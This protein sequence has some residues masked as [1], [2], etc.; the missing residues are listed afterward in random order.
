MNGSVAGVPGGGAPAHGGVQDGGGDG[1]DGGAFPGVG[2]SFSSGDFKPPDDDISLS[3]MDSASVVPA[4]AKSKLAIRARELRTIR[5]ECARVPLWG[6]HTYR[7]PSV[8]K[9]VRRVLGPALSA[10]LRKVIA[11]R[12][13]DGTTR[14][15]LYVVPGDVEDV[16]S[17]LRKR[18]PSFRWHCSRPVPWRARTARS[19]VRAPAITAQGHCAHRRVCVATLNIRGISKKRSH[20]EVYLR[21]GAVTVCGLQE[22]LC[23][24]QAWRLRIFGYGILERTLDRDQPGVLGVALLFANGVQY[25][26]V[27]RAQS[28]FCIFARA[29]GS[30]L[31]GPT[32]FGSCY[33]PC[34]GPA[35]KLAKLALETEL[36]YLRARFPTTPVCVLGDFNHDRAALDRLLVKFGCGVVCN[37]GRGNMASRHVRGRACKRA[38]DH[39]LVSVEHQSMFR[40]SRVDRTFDL[41]DHWA[42]TASMKL[43]SLPVG[44]AIDVEVSEEEPWVFVRSDKWQS[45]LDKARVEGSPSVAEFVCRSGRFAELA[46]A[47]GGGDENAPQVVLPD[48]HACATAFNKA[49]L[50]VAESAQLRAPKRSPIVPANLY[51]RGRMV[52]AINAARS[53]F[54]RWCTAC[55]SGADPDEVAALAAAH[56]AL[57]VTAHRVSRECRRAQ[58]YGFVAREAER[59]ESTPRGLWAFARRVQGQDAKGRTNGPTRTLRPLRDPDG[60][61]ELV[62]DVHEIKSIIRQ[63]FAGLAADPNPLASADWDRVACPGGRP[64]GQCTPH[65][66]PRVPTQRATRWFDGCVDVAS[67]G[68]GILCHLTQETWDGF[69]RGFYPC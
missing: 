65:W 56:D 47:D 42:V 45:V 64:V 22:T 1:A 24:S 48:V 62:M 21:Q 60:G 11:V 51:P 59:C 46:C 38:V 37:P 10:S 4:A 66:A 50:E 12:Q 57:E 63:H 44:A 36:S 9:I 52:R 2:D 61:N 5:R 69:W 58:W 19:G 17:A 18:R 39:I 13:S 33:I 6:L 20:L 32:I 43:D 67:G 54:T 8:W 14:H 23:S 49:V 29:S 55:D 27:G 34:S 35:R 28:P 68:S 53:A 31:E 30:P 41:S 7:V 26:E 15:D 40:R 25:V 16:V 3:A